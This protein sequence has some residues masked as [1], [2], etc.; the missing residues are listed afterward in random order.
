MHKMAPRM[1]ASMLHSLVLYLF[2]FSAALSDYI[3][4]G[5]TFEDF[6]IH[7]SNFFTTFHSAGK[8]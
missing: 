3:H 2:L 8:F 4:Q 1:T 6:T 5:G 7:L